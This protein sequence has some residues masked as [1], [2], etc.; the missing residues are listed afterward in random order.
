[1]HFLKLIFILILGFYFTQHFHYLI[2]MK[3]SEVEDPHPAYAT[4]A[5]REKELECLA[6]NI[7]YEAG[8]EPFEGKV[9]VAQVTINRTKSKDFPKDIC[10]VVYERNIVYN[11]VICQFSWFCEAQTKVKPIHAAHRFSP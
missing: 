2:D 11:K 1:M 10:A 3:M 5:Q 8:T 7:Y 4:M 6:K 9:A